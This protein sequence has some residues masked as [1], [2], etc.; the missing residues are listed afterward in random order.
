MYLRHQPLEVGPISSIWV[1]PRGASSMETFLIDDRSVLS[2]LINEEKL[3]ATVFEALR[4]LVSED[5]DLLRV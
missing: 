4:R 3:T 1:S 2:G 5:F